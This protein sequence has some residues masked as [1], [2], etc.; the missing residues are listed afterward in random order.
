MLEKQAVEH[1]KQ[2]GR[3]WVTYNN[4]FNE[5]IARRTAVSELIED[6]NNKGKNK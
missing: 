6:Y 5:D 1:F 4:Q 3:E 2:I